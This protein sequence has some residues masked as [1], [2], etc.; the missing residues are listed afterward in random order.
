MSE[1]LKNLGKYLTDKRIKLNYSQNYL[2]S[3]LNVSSQTIYKYEHGLSSPDFSIIGKYAN[4]L[5]T[6]LDDLINIKYDSID[7]PDNL[8]LEFDPVKFST[9]LKIL[10]IKNNFTLSKV[11]ELINVKYQT[12]S[13]WEKGESYPSISQFISLGNLYNQSLHNLYY[14]IDNNISNDNVIKDDEII[15]NTNRMPILPWIISSILLILF[16]ANI[17][18]TSK[19]ING[20]EYRETTI[21]TTSFNNE[22]ATTISDDDN[23]LISLT[24]Y[25]VNHY[26][27]NIY[28]DEYTLVSSNNY[29]IISNSRVSPSTNNYNGFISPSAEEVIIT[30]ENNIINYY[31]E[32]EKYTISF[33]T[34][35]G[36]LI[37]DIVVKYG[38]SIHINTVPFKEGSTFIGWYLDD[39]YSNILSN[40]IINGVDR[41]ITLYAR[42][43]SDPALGSYIYLINDNKVTIT[44]FIEGNIIFIE[45]EI[46]GYPVKEINVV[47]SDITPIYIKIPNT[48]EKITSFNITDT[49]CAFDIYFD[50]SLEEW[51]N[52]DFEC[53]VLKHSL[54]NFY[55]KDN[56]GNYIEP[57][58]DIIIN[59]NIINKYSMSYFKNITSV[60]INE[61]ATSIEEGAF[62]GCSSL[63][64]VDLPSSLESIEIEVF[65]GCTSL[66]K[67]N[68]HDLESWF[69]IDFIIYEKDAN[70]SNNPLCFGHNLYLNDVLL[71]KITVPSSITNIKPNIFFGSTSIKEIIVEDTVIIIQCGA[72]SGLKNLESITLPFVGKNR[73]LKTDEYQYP[74]GYIFGK[75]GYE[76]S[77]PVPQKYI[78]P[79][80]L[81]DEDYFEVFYIPGFLIEII[82]TGSSFIPDYAFYNCHIDDITLPST[83]ES[84]GEKAFYECYVHNIYIPEGVKTIGNYAFGANNELENIT[85]PSSVISIG[86]YA[87]WG[88]MHLSTIILSNN[89][90]VIEE[91]LFSGCSE[92]VSITIPSSVKRIK[93]NAFEYCSSLESVFINEGLMVIDEVA[94]ANCKSLTTFN[95]PSTIT[96]LNSSLF[97][98]D[99]SLVTFNYNGL[100]DDWALI[101]KADDWDSNTREY[102]IICLDG[103][104]SKND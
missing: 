34:N 60:T 61:G 23:N 95:F 85:I 4:L 96:F 54:G 16:I 92:L 84:I 62:Y 101:E 42:Y 17:I 58:G 12:I 28:N 49:D 82:I 6:S 15:K 71:T 19:I 67:I 9:N 98:G 76:G 13:K 79:E 64:K 24:S 104:I 31:Y 93:L 94:F 46:E 80:I 75:V 90:E 33:D 32:R 87:F 41:N 40:N 103:T 97:R 88:C 83:I 55:Y 39:N 2:A 73:C 68:I 43:N 30:E 35:L 52:I 72:F 25:T 7:S 44:S 5:K 100:K 29:N 18:I 69:D 36:T 20:F 38:T 81:V 91:G 70:Y 14:G 102:V 22:D 27:E 26:L 77:S 8:E 47:S 45:D 51:L 63:T 78:C 59:K 21:S 3:L 99:I 65:S 56:N 53:M 11:Q 57:N 66:N 74:F 1:Y 10:R 89:I 37:N 48:I 50:G 86:K